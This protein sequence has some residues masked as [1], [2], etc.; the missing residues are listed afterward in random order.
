MW[1][2]QGLS[3]I[4]YYERGMFLYEWISEEYIN[5]LPNK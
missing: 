2:V 3:K 4:Q 5:I 1:Q